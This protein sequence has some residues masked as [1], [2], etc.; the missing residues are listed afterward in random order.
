MTGCFFL[1]GDPGVPLL[2]KGCCCCQSSTLKLELLSL[3][4]SFLFKLF[5][6]LS[7]TLWIIVYLV[8]VILLLFMVKLKE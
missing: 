8:S 5:V 1:R 2:N 6:F 7:L 3:K 4:G